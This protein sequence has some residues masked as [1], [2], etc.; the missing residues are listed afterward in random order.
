MKKTGNTFLFKTIALFLFFIST[1][2]VAQ[3]NLTARASKKTLG[4]N[5]RFRLE[6]TINNQEAD[7]FK[8]PNFKDFKVVGGP[9][10]SVSNS[11]TFIN[12]KAQSNFTKTFTYM[13]EP[14]RKGTFT[15]PP[16]TIQYKGKTIESNA[17]TIQV[18]DP[19]DL[20]K[21]PNDPNYIA[22][23]NVKMVT[24]ISN[25]NPYVGE[26]IY[27]EYRL[28]V[29]QMGING[30]DVDTPPN[31]EGFWSQ[32]LENERPQFKDGTYKG[33]PWQYATLHKVLLI[34]QSSGEL[35]VN[36]M[37]ADLTIGVPTGRGDFFGNMI[38]RNVNQKLTSAKRTIHVKALPS[39]GKPLN[40]SGAVGDFSYSVNTSRAV[41]KANES[42]QIKVKVS[43]KGNLKLFEIPS[44]KT[45]K[46]LEVYDPE[47][48]ENVE[49]TTSGLKGSIEN[50][51]TVVPQYKGKFII[52]A[53]SFTFFNPKEEKYQ[54]ITSDEI[55]LDV[56]EGKELVTAASSDYTN[57]T[58]KQVVGK[59]D[60]NFRY[61]QTSTELE[62]IE[63]ED[64]Y[65]SKWFYI[66]LLLPLVILPLGVF[67]SKKQRELSK[68]IARNKLKQADKL[69]KKYLAS[70]K[71]ELGNK[72][73][74]YSSLEKALHNYLKAKL[75]VET[76]DIS[77]DKIAEILKGKGVS[78]EIIGQFTA[79]FAACE[80]ARYAASSEAKMQE[81][82]EKAKQAIT[83]ID[84]N[85]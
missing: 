24:T 67:A 23:Q 49:V 76:T 31:Y 81:D 69:T 37:S 70:A 32:T 35:S 46:E 3:V 47:R 73:T 9:S 43:G 57:G 80:Y 50:A 30:F 63:K 18:V 2:L 25:E 11:Y 53:T 38:T 60:Q 79:V 51:Y 28:Y 4:E 85:L 22:S 68:D 66:L 17:I 56:T 33:E 54:T 10:Q 1:T 21:D 64:F 8:L 71:K 41:F 40:F 83:L 48:K 78:D 15:L 61:V 5:Q 14:K 75:R 84:K 52:P 20:P 27:V 58:I 77:K 59:S 7:D 19:V 44:I 34:P 42:A 45:P 55:V 74:F 6:Y 26:P 82:F 65:L 16:A 72:E 39:K 13:V 36:P 62:S 29:N 12:G